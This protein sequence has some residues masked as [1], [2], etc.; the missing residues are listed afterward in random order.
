MVWRVMSPPWPQPA[1]SSYASAGNSA[2]KAGD[3]ALRFTQDFHHRAATAPSRSPRKREGWSGR[4]GGTAARRCRVRRR[5]CRVAGR[6]MPRR[7]RRR[8]HS[9]ATG[10]RGSTH[11]T[12]TRSFRRVRRARRHRK[13]RPGTMGVP[14]R[15]PV[16]PG[17]RRRRSP[18]RGRRNRR[19][20][21]RPSPSLG[22]RSHTTR[23][24]PGSRDPR[25]AA[26]RPPGTR[27]RAPRADCVRWRRR[28]HRPWPPSQGQG[29]RPHGGAESCKGVD[30]KT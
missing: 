25:W 11:T 26:P 27:R 23:P 18:R 29:Q 21:G 3:L 24:A 15:R 16:G 13:A 10:R 1:S 14:P 5:T 8:A 9:P 22:L 28:R 17:R 6:V 4:S 19:P 20:V 7:P 2:A 12:T 30:P